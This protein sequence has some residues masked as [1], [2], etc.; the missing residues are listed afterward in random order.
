M[1]CTCQGQP[2]PLDKR[3]QALE[4][5]VPIESLSSR[6]LKPT[7]WIHIEARRLHSPTECSFIAKERKVIH[8]VTIEFKVIR[9][10][11]IAELEHVLS[12]RD[13]PTRASVR[14][15]SLCDLSEF[16]STIEVT[17]QSRKE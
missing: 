2:T 17:L 16:P 9:V 8:D 3:L 7:R 14:K 15:F 1:F 5:T 11:Q 4:C 12:L 13:G 10:D 6:I